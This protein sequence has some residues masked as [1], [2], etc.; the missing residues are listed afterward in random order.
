VPPDFVAA[1]QEALSGLEKIGVSGDD[2][3]NALLQGALAR[4]EQG[5]ITA[6]RPIVRGDWMASPSR[7][8]T[9]E[10]PTNQRTS[11]RSCVDERWIERASLTP[12]SFLLAFREIVAVRFNAISNASTK[13]HPGRETRKGRSRRSHAKAHSPRQ[14]APQKTI[15]LDGKT[16]LIKTDTLGAAGR[17]RLCNQ[18]LVTTPVCIRVGVIRGRQYDAAPPMRKTSAAV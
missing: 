18:Q 10:Q 2:I 8:S 13:P 15:K 7:L 6:I 14:R 3:K 16:R 4:L 11:F 12:L 1:I 5:E 17:R 9:I